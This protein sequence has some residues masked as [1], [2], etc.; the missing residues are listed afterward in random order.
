MVSLDYLS[1]EIAKIFEK[2]NIETE[3]VTKTRFITTINQSNLDDKAFRFL[4][5]RQIDVTKGLL[6]DFLRD[7][8]HKMILFRDHELSVI[9]F[10][11][12]AKRQLL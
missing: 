6:H 1:C 12:K 8:S 11:M 4:N 10:V 2:L 3:E 7:E 5:K 9:R